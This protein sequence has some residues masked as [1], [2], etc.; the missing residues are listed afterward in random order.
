MKIVNNI[1]VFSTRLTYL[2]YMCIIEYPLLRNITYFYRGFLTTK[3]R[4]GNQPMKKKS[5]TLTVCCII[6]TIWGFFAC[7]RHSNECVFPN[8]CFERFGKEKQTY[9]RY[10][11]NDAGS[12]ADKQ[13][14]DSLRNEV[15]GYDAGMPEKSVQNDVVAGNDYSSTGEYTPDKLESVVDEQ[16]EQTQEAGTPQEAPFEPVVDAHEFHQMELVA[17][18][19]QESSP[20]ADQPE[21]TANEQQQDQQI[22]DMTFVQNGSLK[23]VLVTKK[24]VIYVAGEQNV[25][26][27]AY[28]VTPLKEGGGANSNQRYTL[29]AGDKSGTNAY[30]ALSGLVNKVTMFIDGKKVAQSVFSTLGEAVFTP[31]Y[32]MAKDTKY[33][34]SFTVDF[35][36]QRGVPSGG[37]TFYAGFACKKSG[38]GS[39][40]GKQGNYKI[41]MMGLSSGVNFTEI[42]TT[43]ATTGMTEQ[44][45]SVSVYKAYVQLGLSPNSQSGSAT[46]GTNSP[47][48]DL[49]ILVKGS[50]STFAEFS[51]ITLKFI[52]TCTLANGSSSWKSLDGT[53]TYYSWTA[54]DYTKNVTWSGGINGTKL[55][56]AGGTTKTVRFFADTTVCGNGSNLL[57][58]VVVLSVTYRDEINGPLRTQYTQVFGNVL[59]Y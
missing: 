59:S 9:E 34:V 57:L 28:D 36:D 15:L 41:T 11:P 4:K 33:R 37:I 12:P 27:V 10:W 31:S 22:P 13:H 58:Q 39:C 32:M 50:S 45:F 56:V 19:G 25:P 29:W 52:S 26:L 43:G 8:P 40:W 54:A 14:P 30:S 1:F 3:D 48:I 44:P 38:N 18:A 46:P 6:L 35:F 7:G 23:V 21:N 55:V 49:D 20:E 2:S 51:D 17:D 53:T 5:L 47:I 42:N 16:Q 24:P